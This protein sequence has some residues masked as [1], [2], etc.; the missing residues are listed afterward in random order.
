MTILLILELISNQAVSRFYVKFQ[1][2][3]NSK[4]SIPISKGLSVSEY[5][6]IT[7]EDSSKNKKVEQAADSQYFAAPVK[8]MAIDLNMNLEI[9]PDAEIQ[10][11]FD[12]KAGD[13]MKGH[14]S[15][16]NL[17]VNL[18]KKGD[19]SIYGDY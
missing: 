1:T 6:F 19:F 4:L 2:K 17:N 18:N 3:K 15:S 9:T 5:S 11:I 12:S 10:I 7:V 16:P 14:G 13:V 8:Q